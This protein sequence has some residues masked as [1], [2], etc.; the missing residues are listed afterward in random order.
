M[1]E[2]LRENTLPV[3]DL[4]CCFGLLRCVVSN[5]LQL[6]DPERLIDEN[7][8][9]V[10]PTSLYDIPLSAPSRT[11]ELITPPYYLPNVDDA[12]CVEAEIVPSDGEKL[13]SI[14]LSS[15]SCD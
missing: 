14:V 15:V 6:N 1:I 9:D 11:I 13:C 2:S 7:P 4:S 8:L 5:G 10:D 12:D 3:L